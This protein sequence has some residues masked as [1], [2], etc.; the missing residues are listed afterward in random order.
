MLIFEIFVGV[1]AFVIGQSQISS[2]FSYTYQIFIQ[3]FVATRNTF[4]NMITKY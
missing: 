4:C 1:G 2:F 3:I